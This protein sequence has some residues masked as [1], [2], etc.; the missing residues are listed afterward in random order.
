LRSADEKDAAIGIEAEGAYEEIKISRSNLASD[1][2]KLYSSLL[3]TVTAAAVVV[4]LVVALSSSRD[5]EGKKRGV[6][7]R[8]DLV[9]G[10]SSSSSGEEREKE[11][12]AL[13]S[14]F[15][16]FLFEV[17]D[18]SFSDRREGRLTH[19]CVVLFLTAEG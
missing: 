12:D 8:E 1:S 5:G 10:A 18:G 16:K 14:P 15:S 19:G 9:F 7:S 6:S 11:R 13:V 17:M 2:S 4:V 3:L